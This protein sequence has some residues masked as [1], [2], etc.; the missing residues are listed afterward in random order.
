MEIWDEILAWPS[1][2]YRQGRNRPS[3]R[4]LRNT[5][6]AGR[7]NRNRHRE[8]PAALSPQQ[9]VNS[10]EIEASALAAWGY[11]YQ[12]GPQDIAVGANVNF[13]NNGPLNGIE[14]APGSAAIEVTLSGTYN[15]IFSLYTS[16]NNPQDWA[17]VV[18]GQPQSRFT[19]AGQTITAAATLKLDT[20][21]RVTIRNVGTIP[22]PATL[23]EDDAITAF[24]MIYKTD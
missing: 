11:V 24:V 5:R 16:Q 14:H 9:L 1:I 7:S 4:R 13:N 12:M 19:S 2:R 23:R 17:V 21:D 22:D 10:L 18:N 8:S 20:M 3:V 15:I 6:A